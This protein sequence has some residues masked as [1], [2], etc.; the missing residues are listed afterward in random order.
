MSDPSTGPPTPSPDPL[1]REQAAWAQI[2]GTWRPLHGDFGEHGLS[3]EWHDFRIDRDL[4]W[5]RSFHPRSLEICLNFSGNGILQDG[6]AERTL[7]PNQVAIYTLQTKR[8]RAVR[9]ANS[10]HRF[11]TVELSPKF[12]RTHCGGELEKLKLPIRRFIEHGAKAPPYL[13]IKTLP[14]ALLAARV[15]FVQPPVPVPA[16]RAWY[17]GRVLEIL[18]QTIYL[19]EDPGELFCQ[20][21][22]RTNRERSERV[23]YLIE[24][25]LANPPSLEML[26]EEV[27]CSTFYLSRIFAQETGASI[28][29]YLRMKR[30][31]KAAELLRNGKA[32]VT[33]AALAVGYSSLSAF[34]KA[35]VEQMGC[36]AGLYPHFK[37][38]GRK[39]S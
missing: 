14:A 6:A 15:Q 25:D 27:G 39:E 33:E 2:E 26:A 35:F 9:S 5:G 11:L 10:L 37:I 36:C 32:N 4:D 34:S 19:D 20:K 8:L 16:R 24:R 7:G 29:K 38:P 3:V 1:H 23:R 22:Q 21:H 13:E 31:E 28:P 30:I 12:L 17:L 18:S